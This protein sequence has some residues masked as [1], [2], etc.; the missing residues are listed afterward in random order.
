MNN[1]THTASQSPSAPQM[2]DMLL[3]GK[4]L[5]PWGIKGH[6]KV[7]SFLET[8]KELFSLSCYKEA[9][10]SSPVLVWEQVSLLKPP[11]LFKARMLTI[12]T[13]T[14]AEQLGKQDLYVSFAEIKTRQEKLAPLDEDTFYCTELAGMQVLSHEGTV[15]GTVKYTH[16]FGGG[17]ILEVVD[18]QGIY[19]FMVHFGAPFVT[20][21]DRISRTVTLGPRA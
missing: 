7:Q 10:Q 21:V 13:C 17:D 6:L 2:D 3:V 8:P 1:P 4:I 11:A 20:N 9:T 18:A 14:Q 15:L 19:L 12:E 5:G 16:N